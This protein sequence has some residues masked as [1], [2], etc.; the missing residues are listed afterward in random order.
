MQH[1]RNAVIRS[2]TKEEVI[3]TGLLII[4]LDSCTLK[5]KEW[6][7]RQALYT[8]YVAALRLFN[9]I[10]EYDKIGG[11]KKELSRLCQQIFVVN[12]VWANQNKAMVAMINLQSRGITED[13]ILQLNSFLENNGYADMKPDG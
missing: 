3:L 7:R 4:S 8:T 11:L 6:K 5:K 1:L 10:R 13:K 12:G 9:D 2:L